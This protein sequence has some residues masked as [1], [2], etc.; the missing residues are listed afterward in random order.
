[1]EEITR[2]TKSTEQK[3]E[4]LE[5]TLQKISGK[6]NVS[7]KKNENSPLLLEILYN[8]LSNL[9]KKLIEK[10]GAINFLLMQKNE[11]NNISS[12]NK[13]VTENKKLHKRKDSRETG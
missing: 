11:I 6:S 5:V 13:T 10:N 12:V 1:M 8:H 3:F 4:E 9:E 7:Y 2:F